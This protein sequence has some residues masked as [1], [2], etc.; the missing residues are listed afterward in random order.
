[1]ICFTRDGLAPAILLAELRD[2]QIAWMS[3]ATIAGMPVIRACITSFRT[4]EQDIEFVVNEMNELFA[5]RKH[6]KTA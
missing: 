3:E 6:R 2:K 4:T 5:K 1:M